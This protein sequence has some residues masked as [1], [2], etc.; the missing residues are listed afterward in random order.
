MN[1]PSCIVLIIAFAVV[2]LF[3]IVVFIIV[4]VVVV[5]VVIVEEIDDELSIENCR[6]IKIEKTIR[7][8][9]NKTR[10]K[11]MTTNLIENR[12][13][14]VDVDLKSKK[15]FNRIYLKIYC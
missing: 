9:I 11:E 2:S 13:E 12:L 15:K 1:I 6:V 3:A 5:V 10:S 8:T 4:I 7:P 14:I